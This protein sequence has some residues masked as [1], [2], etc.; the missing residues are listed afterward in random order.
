MRHVFASFLTV[1]FLCG[2]HASDKTKNVDHLVILVLTGVQACSRI[3]ELARD[4]CEFIAQF[5]SEKFNS[6]CQF[7]LPPYRERIAMQLN[8]FKQRFAHV[9]ATNQ[10]SLQEMDDKVR[11]AFEHR[12]SDMI[13]RKVSLLELEQL[14]GAIRGNQCESIEDYLRMKDRWP[15]ES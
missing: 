4:S 3:D 6:V 15:G 1:L 8:D 14:I 13:S 9:I 11:T 2:A 7:E 5:D 12:Y 10:S